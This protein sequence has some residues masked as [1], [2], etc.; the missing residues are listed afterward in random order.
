MHRDHIVWTVTLIAALLGFVAAS[1]THPDSGR[2]RR[3]RQGGGGGDRLSR[4]VPEG[5]PAP[6]QVADSVR[7][8]GYW[9][10]GFFDY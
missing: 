9:I 6:R 10:P 4:C 7:K 8:V 3:D 1:T 2:A 5:K